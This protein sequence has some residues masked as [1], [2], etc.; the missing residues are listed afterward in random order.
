MGKILEINVHRSSPAEKELVRK[1]IVK[2]MENNRGNVKETLS[3]LEK[4]GIKVCGYHV[5]KTWKAYQKGGMEAIRAQKVGAPSGHKKLT[6]EQ[7]FEIIKKITENTPEKLEL[8][9][10]L[11][12]R[13]LVS[14]LIKRDYG[15]HMPLSTMGKYLR[16]WGFT[17]QRPTKRHY[18][19]DPKA[20]E[21]WQTE[22]FP[23]IKERAESEDAQ[24]FWGDETG[25]HNETNCV[26]GYAIAGQTPILPVGNEHIKINMISAISNVGKVFFMFFLASINQQFFIEY[27]ER[28]IKTTERKIFLIV[29]NLKVHHGKLVK[30]WINGHKD[31]IE[32]YFLPAYSPQI[33]PDE[34]LNNNLK[35]E[36]SKRGY[37]KTL[38]E[39]EDK[40]HSTMKAFQAD[41]AHIANFFKNKNVKYAALYN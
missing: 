4:T 3:L 39:L 6:E 27:M 33:N 40:A 17:A 28:L 14:E 22:V 7:E 31:R 30:E 25:V 36:M 2:L 13:E 1:I 21:K 20:V 19:Q 41:E 34:Y 12:T 8:G 5:R 38:D 9:A 18:K 23:E 10:Y 29:D 32:L 24:I 16:E 26:K 11:W 15:V 37:A 35:C